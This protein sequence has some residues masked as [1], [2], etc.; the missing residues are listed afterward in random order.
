VSPAVLRLPAVSAAGR[1]IVHRC[2]PCRQLAR[3]R[4]ECEWDF[5]RSPMACPGSGPPLRRLRP[6]TSGWL[7]RGVAQRRP[8]QLLC[9]GELC[10]R[11]WSLL[12]DR[13]DGEAVPACSDELMAGPSPVRIQTNATD[14]LK[15]LSRVVLAPD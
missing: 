6:G 14:L 10:R 8:R 4:R 9:G 5:G 2:P 7:S 15:S 1:L 12:R 3:A 11:R 13:H